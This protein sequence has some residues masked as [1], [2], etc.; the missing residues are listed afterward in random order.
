M[1]PTRIFDLL[2]YYKK[3]YGNVSD[4]LAVKRKGI[5]EKYSIDDYMQQS[6]YFSY[7]LMEL[8]F[9]KGDKI[10]TVSNNRPEWNI[11]DMGSS[12]VG[13][14]HV[15]IYPTISTEEFE[16]IFKHAE[17]KIII[18]S[19]A[20][21]YVKMLPIVAK[22]DNLNDIYTFNQIEGAKN[23]ADII[24]LGKANAHK[25]ETQLEDIKKSI[26]PRDLL[27]IIYTSG[28]T[29]QPKGVMLCHENFLSNVDATYGVLPAQPGDKAISFLP[30]CHVLER[31]VNYLFQFKGVK[32]YYAESIDTMV[33][34]MQEIKP[35][36]FVAVPRVLEKIYD[37]ILLKGKSL[38]GIKRKI[39][40]WAVELA[41]KFELNNANGALYAKQLAVADKLI[42]SLWRAALGGNVKYIIVGGAALQPRLARTFWAAGIHV[43]EGYGLTET[44]PVISVNQD[45][46]P[47]IEFGSVGPIIDNVQVKIAEDGEILTKGPNLM[48]GYYNNVEK[49]TEAI[50]EEGWFHTGDIGIIL[51]H[52]ILK[53]TDRKKEIFKLSGGKYVA[54]QAIENK[55]KESFF[56]EQAMV[57]GEGEKFAAALISP[58]Y[59]FIHDW[60]AKEKIHFRDNI[61]LLEDSRIIERMQE[62]IEKVNKTLGKTETIKKFLMVCEQWTTDNGALSPTLKL[63]RKVLKKRYAVKLDRLYGYTDKNGDLLKRDEN[64]QLIPTGLINEE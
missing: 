43:Y 36:I 12:Q 50:D 30:L 46:Y 34:N 15:P 27:S 14:V 9:K 60:C 7:G 24:E 42:F 1:E 31:M 48:L 17:A 62:E 38:T 56:I 6:N 28:T 45:K 53:I 18:V 35:D 23:F 2:P 52:N 61:D 57:V 26:H 39:F 20:I 21:L 33:E 59:E 22:L 4:A 55:L 51:P 54:P 25:Y 29:G 37:K 16:F 58:N 44:S 49:T 8:G 40:H 10:A 19:T 13:V 47:Y 32:V 5:W 3:T 63:K 41:L 11:V 64:G